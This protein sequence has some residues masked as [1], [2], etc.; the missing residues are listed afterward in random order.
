MC[1]KN[2]LFAVVIAL[3]Y[4]LPNEDFKKFKIDL[5]RILKHYFNESQS[6]SETD[7]NKYM[8]FPLNWANVTRYKK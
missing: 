2:D 4:L 3:R 8:G 5:S 1:G 7:L 6:I